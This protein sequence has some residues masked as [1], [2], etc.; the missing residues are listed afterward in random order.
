LNTGAFVLPITFEYAAFSSMITTICAYAGGGATPA[1]A[2]GSGIRAAPAGSADARLA[3][4]TAITT[5]TNQ[6]FLGRMPI[7]RRQDTVDPP[8]G[9]S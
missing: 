6:R 5:A 4:K 9:F 3:P 1:S 7:R 8:P 2:H